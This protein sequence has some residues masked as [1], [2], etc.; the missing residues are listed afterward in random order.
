MGR[1]DI[2]RGKHMLLSGGHTF[3]AAIVPSVDFPD[4][5]PSV[6]HHFHYINPQDGSKMK[7]IQEDGTLKDTC[8]L[9]E[10][11]VDFQRFLLHLKINMRGITLVFYSFVELCTFV[12][13]T[14]SVCGK[15]KK[16]FLQI[17]LDIVENCIVC[18]EG[19]WAKGSRGANFNPIQPV[20]RPVHCADS[21]AVLVRSVCIRVPHQ[22]YV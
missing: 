21:L 14:S 10:S 6:H 16:T 13:T 9:S 22:G 19:S 17:F 4:L 1:G 11:L 3:H 5:S 18:E 2:F 12:K 7:F 20:G 8:S 15:P